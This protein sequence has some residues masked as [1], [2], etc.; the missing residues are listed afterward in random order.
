MPSRADAGSMSDAASSMR[1]AGELRSDAAAARD[2]AAADAA[3]PEL[4]AQT[5]D[6]GAKTHQARRL[7]SPPRYLGSV[8]NGAACSREYLTAGFAPVAAEGARFPLFLYFIGTRFSPDDQSALHDSAAPLAVTEALATRGFVALSAAYDNTPVAWLSDHDNQLSC[9]FSSANAKS[10]LAAAC[11]LPQV[12]CGLG[13]ATW[14]H[15][16]GGYVAHMAFSSDPRVRASWATGYGGNAPAT[17]PRDRLRVVNGENDGNIGS[18]TT[19]HGITGLTP[20]QCMDPD[21]C[22]RADGSGW[23]IVRAS[24]LHNP[25]AT[26]DHCW[27]DRASCGGTQIQLDPAWLDPS[28]SAPFALH[29]NADW[30]ARTVRRR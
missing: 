24:A 2:A 19:L 14:G 23:A 12:D 9:L 4:D 6:T 7:E 28:S 16:Q 27:F 29:R 15:S 20:A 13:I 1:D 21:H 18:A 25:M 11:A 30:V 10:L 3:E 22:F 8:D 5:D 26:A 17:L